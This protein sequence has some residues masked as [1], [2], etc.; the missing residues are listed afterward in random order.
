MVSTDL[1]RLI[2]IRGPSGSG[3]STVARRV[4]ERASR[5]ICLIE[6]DHYRF[7]FRPAGGGSLPN[8]ATVHRMIEHN[9]LSALTDG[10]D[11]VLDG[12]LS[13]EAYGAVLGRV[14]SAGVSTNRMYSFDVSLEETLRRHRVRRTDDC[15]FTEDDMREWYPHAR[16]WGH[17]LEQLIHETTSV[18]DIV[19]AI[20]RDAR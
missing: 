8:S 9:V 3:K 1:P 13:Q 19:A 11:V 20:L 16:P 7:I 14:F 6:Q 10:Y 4:F 5:R 2:V 17:E 12:I 15:T 18:D